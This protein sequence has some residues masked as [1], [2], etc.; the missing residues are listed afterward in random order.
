METNKANVTH[1]LIWVT[2]IVIVA[3]IC[4]LIWAQVVNHGNDDKVKIE[5]VRAK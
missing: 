3:I 2:G 1:S 5:Q 4:S